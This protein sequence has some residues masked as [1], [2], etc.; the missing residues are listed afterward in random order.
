MASARSNA[1]LEEE[2]ERVGT[3]RAHLERQ[4]VRDPLT[5]LL[6]RRGQA[7]RPVT[8]RGRP[9]ATWCDLGATHSTVGRGQVVVESTRTS[10]PLVS[11]QARGC[12]SVVES[13]GCPSRRSWVRI[14]P[15]AFPTGLLASF[16]SPRARC[17]RSSEG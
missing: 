11:A 4:A 10:R 15:S 13:V 14:L 9:E 17:P 12:S 2:L 16:E 8:L 7:R 6:N 5:N 1:W 3:R